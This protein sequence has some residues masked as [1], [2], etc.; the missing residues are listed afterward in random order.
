MAR[1]RILSLPEGNM[2]CVREWGGKEGALGKILNKRPSGGC[3]ARGRDLGVGNGREGANPKASITTPK[4]HVSS[5]GARGCI[6][7]FSGASDRNPAPR[8]DISPASRG[9][10]RPRALCCHLTVEEGKTSLSGGSRTGC[11]SEGWAEAAGAPG[12]VWVDVGVC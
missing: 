1:Q 8:V 4:P 2:G 3:K 5:R 6:P 7:S 11:G 10:R 12:V 9:P